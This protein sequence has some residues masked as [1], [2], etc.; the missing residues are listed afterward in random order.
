M[1]KRKLVTLDLEKEFEWIPTEE[2]DEEKP[3]KFYYKALSNR[4]FEKFNS[5]LFKNEEGKL[6]SE[7]GLVDYDTVKLKLVKVENVD[8]DGS[9]KTIQKENIDDK[10]MDTLPLD[11]ISDLAS[12]IRTTSILKGKEIE[13]LKKP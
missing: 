6:I 5:Q 7:Q 12:A 3:T 13:S 2:I 4:E 11:W 1:A 8:L 10:F 9:L